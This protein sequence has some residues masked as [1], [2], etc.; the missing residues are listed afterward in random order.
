MLEDGRCGH[1]CV[2]D[3]SVRGDCQGSQVAVVGS[4]IYSNLPAQSSYNAVL[5]EKANSTPLR[6]H[7]S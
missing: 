4:H 5:G 6:L 2:S 7:C 3:T 1:I